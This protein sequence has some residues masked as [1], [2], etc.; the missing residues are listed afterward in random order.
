MKKVRSCRDTVMRI[1]DTINPIIG[2]ADPAMTASLLKHIDAMILM[3]QSPASLYAV[4]DRI[5]AAGGERYSGY[6]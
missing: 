1:L 3:K 6:A 5:H 2:A 4:I